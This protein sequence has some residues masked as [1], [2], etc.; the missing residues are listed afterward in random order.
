MAAIRPSLYRAYETQRPKP[1]KIVTNTS[2][3]LPLRCPDH[4]VQPDIQHSISAC[5]APPAPPHLAPPHPTPPRSAPPRACR[6]TN[7]TSPARSAPFKGIDCLDSGGEGHIPILYFQRDTFRVKSSRRFPIG[8]SHHRRGAAG[9]LLE[10]PGR[11]ERHRPVFSFRVGSGRRGPRTA[12]RWPTPLPAS[13]ACK[14]C[15]LSV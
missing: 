1:R 14:L 11:P 4:T 12:N 7:H 6:P 3:P 13:R 8:D 5:P 10:R 9:A 15:K 2:L